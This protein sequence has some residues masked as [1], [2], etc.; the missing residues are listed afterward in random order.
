MV[1]DV[2]TTSKGLLSASCVKCAQDVRELDYSV[3]QFSKP[4]WGE[5]KKIR[6]FLFKNMYRAE[7]VLIQREHATFVVHQ[8]FE[9]FMNSPQLLPSE[10][11]GAV[12]AHAKDLPRARVIADYI[13]GMTD[14]FAQQEFDRLLETR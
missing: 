11:R 7:P 1:G 12:L 3:I 4:L 8:L 6:K 2:I 14:R 5:L 13:A 9:C 10:W